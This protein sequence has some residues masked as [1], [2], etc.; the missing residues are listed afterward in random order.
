M[1]VPA[2]LHGDELKMAPK[3][4]AIGSE[5]PMAEASEL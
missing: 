3:P 1:A 5:D 2:A 4:D